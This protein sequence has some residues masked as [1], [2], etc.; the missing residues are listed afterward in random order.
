MWDNFKPST[1]TQFQNNLKPL[2][3]HSVRFDGISCLVVRYLKECYSSKYGWPLQPFIV[4]WCIH[5]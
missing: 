4:M 5:K 1:P 2:K 3:K